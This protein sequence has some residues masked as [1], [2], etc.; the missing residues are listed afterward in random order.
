MTNTARVPGWKT[1][2]SADRI[3]FERGD[4]FCVANFSDVIDREKEYKKQG[5]N[6]NGHFYYGA[7]GILGDFIAGGAPI[8]RYSATY[9]NMREAI[10]EAVKASQE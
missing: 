3:T 2:I 10:A 8:R 5:W 7:I 4:W 1:E 6:S 9:F